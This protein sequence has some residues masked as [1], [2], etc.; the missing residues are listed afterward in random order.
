MLRIVSYIVTFCQNLER[1]Y[2]S[3]NRLH[4]TLF[5]HDKHLYARMKFPMTTFYTIAQLRKL[6]NQ[7]AHPSAANLYNLLKKAKLDAV[8]AKTLE[9]LEE[10]FAR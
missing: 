3:K 4:I 2:A 7:S 6:H 5:R 9:A 8:N 1:R 10:I